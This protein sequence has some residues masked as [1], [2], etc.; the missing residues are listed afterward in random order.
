MQI[1][2]LA[3]LGALALASATWGQV[4]ESIAPDDPVA[5]AQ[6][7]LKWPQRSIQEISIDPRDMAE[8]KPADNSADLI[9]SSPPENWYNAS[10]GYQV[11]EWTA[12]NLRYNPLYFEDVGLE[13]YGQVHWGHW[14]AARSSM[15]FYGGV[16]ALPYNMLKVSPH[17]CDTPLGFARPGSPAP[18]THNYL[19]YRN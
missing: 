9:D 16:L 1:A 14:D 4:V 11:V 19:F 8:R 13:R 17:G 6:D 18:A 5:P 15:L 10:Y 3:A 7:D 12:P 2:V